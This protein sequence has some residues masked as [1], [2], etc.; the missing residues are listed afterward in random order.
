MGL[1]NH[2]CQ[3]FCGSVKAQNYI[4]NTVNNN[5]CKTLFKN[6]TSFS[7]AQERSQASLMPL[8]SFT[9]C[10]CPILFNSSAT[11]DRWKSFGDPE[12]ESVWYVPQHTLP[13]LS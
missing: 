10:L 8:N 6:Q 9:L 13:A 11:R 4:F 1:K 3:R 5:L 12:C 7:A 2:F